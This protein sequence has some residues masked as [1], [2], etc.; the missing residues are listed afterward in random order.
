MFTVL[1]K[2]S[3][4]TKSFSL[5][6][7]MVVFV[8]FL[9]TFGWGFVDPFFSIFVNG[10]SET[11]A[12]VGGLIAIM[13]LASL[14]GT[15]PLVRLADKMRETAIMRDGELMYIFAIIFYILA[16]FT[17]RVAFLI[18]AF[19]FNGFA[20]PF[21]VVGAETFLRK[22]TG[23]TTETKSFA[24]YT[25]SHYFGWI[26]GMLIA[27]FTIQYYG[28]KYMFF[29]ILPAAVIGLIVLNHI[30]ERGLRSF[31]WAFRKY[32]HNR[33]D[34]TTF[35]EGV[36]H[37]NRRTL[38]LLMIAFF[39]GVIVMFSFIFMPLFASSIGLDLKHIAL[40]MA[41]MYS[42]FILSFLIS[43]LTDSIKSTT[44]IAMG[45]IIG[46]AS[47]ILL[48]FIVDQ[49][50]VALLA[51]MQSASLAILRPA[52]NGMLTHFTPRRILG[53]VT[54]LNNIALRLGYVVGPIVTGLVADSYGIQMT[55][56]AMAIFAF[57]LAALTLSFRSYEA[58]KTET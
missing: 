12:G 34:M 1:K 37:L 18:P 53:Q 49:L 9:R 45:L 42:P 22:Y 5:G 10:F 4:D 52:Y 2:L 27:A 24:F 46:G 21:M 54:G 31:F 50:W 15:I 8:M 25:M 11:Y 55:F 16:A 35:F 51:T 39:D 23:P 26:L 58:I 13:N 47:F 19:I 36:G 44:V 14:L 33:Q 38:F 29:F 30:R 7:K 28:F 32:F 17:G 48:S 40:L 41:I 57:A 56:L 3:A 43:E 6:V 20:M